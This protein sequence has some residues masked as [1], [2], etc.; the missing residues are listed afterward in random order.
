[1]KSWRKKRWLAKLNEPKRTDNSSARRLPHPLGQ[2]S[3]ALL[4]LLILVIGDA[5]HRRSTPSRVTVPIPAEDAERILKEVD[6]EARGV[7][8]YQAVLKV[9]GKGPEGRFNATQVIVFERPDRVRVELLGAF[10]STRWVAVASKD[11]IIVWFPGRREFVRESEVERVVGALLGVELTSGEVIAALSGAGMPLAGL[12]PVGAVREDGVTRIELD[13]IRI[14][15]EESQVKSA[16]RADYRVS[17]PTSW[18]AAGRPAPDRLEI[19]NEK[20]QAVL[21]VEDLDVNVRL[22]PEAFLVEVP[23][24]ATQ[25]ELAQIGGEAFFV[26]T[27]R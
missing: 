27:S 9:S 24:E 20:L 15:V 16:W 2:L 25:L 7:A 22:H 10:G 6:V 1:M 23:E 14:E 12:H 8:R 18:R 11:E 19:A 5:C 13:E 3:V 17:Y 4:G 26:T 21:R